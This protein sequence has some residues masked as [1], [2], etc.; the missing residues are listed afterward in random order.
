MKQYIRHFCVFVIVSLLL[1]CS[2]TRY[3]AV[4]VDYEPPIDTRSKEIAYQQKMKYSFNEGSISFDNL[5]DGARLNNCTQDNDS[6]FIIQIEA[7]NTP[8]NSSPWYAFRVVST[9]HTNILINISYEEVR[10]RYHPKISRDGKTWTNIKEEYL[11]LA[12]DT[13]G[14]SIR[15]RTD[16]DTTWISAQ[17][18]ENSGNVISFWK[19]QAEKQDFTFKTIGESALGR[20]LIMLDLYNGEKK[21][22]P[23]I[24]IFS[25]QHPPE[26]TGYYAM[27]AFVNELISHNKL[28]ESFLSQYRV[29]VFPLINPDGVDLGHWRHNSGGVDLN[30]DW[31]IYHQPAV[32]I[33]A[34]RIVSESQGNKSEI[35][36]GIDFHSTFRDIFFTNIVDTEGLFTGNFKNEWLKGIS[37]FLDGEK[38]KET[39]SKTY[40]SLTSKNW[41]YNQFGAEGITYEIG[42]TTT[43]DM[44]KK[45]GAGS[46]IIMMKLLLEDEIYDKF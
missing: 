32:R 1:S 17:E 19:K 21:G 36:L 44:I 24:V 25:R 10:H 27:K 28:S 37:D 8:I 20:P 45:K 22:K 15:H 30:R 42:D 46:A 34:D 23:I 5:F 11:C 4:S 3:T 43:R 39:P 13:M 14:I 31:G 18:I 7:E 2:S 41:F 16:S 9:K 38:I 40:P 33:I 29:L 26:V 6:T 35:I 12:S